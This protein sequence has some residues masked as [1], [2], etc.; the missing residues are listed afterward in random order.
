M[1]KV[2]VSKMRGSGPCLKWYIEYQFCI[3]V[4]HYCCCFDYGAGRGEA[5]GVQDAGEG[6][7]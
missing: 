7:Q 5:G 1:G 4:L 3:C 6:V 2:M